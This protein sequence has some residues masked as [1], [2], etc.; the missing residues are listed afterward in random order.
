MVCALLIYHGKNFYDIVSF[1]ENATNTKKT[2]VDY[3]IAH[4]LKNE[5][6]KNITL[7]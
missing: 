6:Y 4:E 1:F 2:E 5:G 3:Q 7:M